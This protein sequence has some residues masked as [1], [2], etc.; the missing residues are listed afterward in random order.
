MG[1]FL[2]FGSHLWKKISDF[3]ENFSRDVSFRT[4]KSPLIFGNHLDSPFVGLRSPSSFCFTVDWHFA[5]SICAL[6]LHRTYS[7]V[8]CTIY[9][10]KITHLA[11]VQIKRGGKLSEL[12][13]KG[14]IAKGVPTAVS[15]SSVSLILCS[16]LC[17]FRFDVICVCVCDICVVC[18]PMHP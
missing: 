13:L 10:N 18:K 15:M 16:T 6:K 1:L 5:V 2:Q 17:R 14:S 8:Q 7:M 3:H 12:C 9:W 11:A 4:R